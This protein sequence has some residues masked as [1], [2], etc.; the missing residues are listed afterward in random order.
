MAL[1]IL[2][3][4]LFFHGGKNGKYEMSYVRK[5]NENSVNE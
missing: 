1:K 5:G 3:V 4:F 2:K